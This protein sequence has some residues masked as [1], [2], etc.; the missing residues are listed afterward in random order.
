MNPRGLMYDKGT[1]KVVVLACVVI[2]FSVVLTGVGSY[3][4]TQG[5]VVEKLKTRDMVYIISSI[6][7]K[8]DGRL[9]RAK[10][11]ALM[12][13]EDPAAIAWVAGGERD[14][15]LGQHIKNK[16]TKIAWNHDYSNAF[17]VSA[18]TRHYWAEGGR[19]IDVISETDPDDSWFFESLKATQPVELNIDSNKE[20]GGTFVFV[21]ALMRQQDKPLA[22]VGVGLSLQEI[23]QEFQRYKIGNK[24]QLWLADSQGKIHLAED[25]E[26]IGLYLNDFVPPELSERIVAESGNVGARPMVLEY[27]N[28]HGETIDLVYLAMK[29][30][31]WKLVFQMPREESI[32]ILNTI[33]LH[34]LIAGTI[35][36]IVIVFIFYF[37]SSR[38]ANPLKRAIALGQELEK[39]VAARTLEL[40]QKNVKIMDSID[41]AQRLQESILPA[42]TDLAAMFADYFVLWQ[43]RDQVGGDFYWARRIGENR[44]LLAVID[45]TGHGVPGAFM[46]MAVNSILDHIATEVN[47]DPARILA[48][49]NRRVKLTLHRSDPR[50]LADDGL[51]IGLCYWENHRRIVFAGAKISLFINRAGQLQL[52]RG[53]NKSLGYRRSRPDLSFS[54]NEW[55]LEP[56]DVFYLTSDGFI[57]QNGG[58]RDYPFGRKRFID[59]LSGLAG[60]ALPQ[61]RDGLI[62]VMQ[63]YMGEETQRDDVTVFGFTFLSEGERREKNDA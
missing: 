34:T 32:A 58:E 16:I 37:I 51:D 2:V 55:I 46:T 4:I 24:S 47:D 29:S 9:E 48:E 40:E 39:Q 35:S 21:N 15:A 27:V 3:W 61:Q 10:E 52:I 36:L 43:P 7:A 50:G 26:Q 44:G 31:D 62:Q 5:E 11:A 22:V 30:T 54:N 63:Q 13:A 45:C 53:N 20:R 23:A 1:M 60:L 14:E 57:D 12:L 6:A 59:T 41:Y 56:G 19:L 28:R 38:I 18:V 33:R 49:L 42:P 25:V 17:V 8:I